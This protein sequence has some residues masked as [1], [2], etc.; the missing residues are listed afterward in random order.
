VDERS[1]DFQKSTI[2]LYADS[3][4]AGGR[5][6][7]NQGESFGVTTTEYERERNGETGSEKRPLEIVASEHSR[8]RMRERARE[9]EIAR[10][11][12]QE[13]ERLIPFMNEGS[14]GHLC[15]SKSS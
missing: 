14:H 2:I 5:A 3:G 11:C 9:R 13:S 12:E 8:D 7:N 6:H 15:N 1:R 4:I 10:A